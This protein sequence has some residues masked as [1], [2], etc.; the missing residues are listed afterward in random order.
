MKKRSV[1]NSQWIDNKLFDTIQNV[2]PIAC[3]DLLVLRACKKKFPELLLVKRKIYP[4]IGKWVLIGGRICYGETIMDTI[5]RQARHELNISVRVLRPWSEE[6]PLCVL[7]ASDADPQKHAIALAYPCE[8][9]KGTISASG[10]EFSEARWFSLRRLP[11]NIGFSK[12]HKREIDKLK[13]NIYLCQK[14]Y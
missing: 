5:N 3:V 10:P 13:S 9:I 14:K 2:I 12:L 8:A 6:H 1:L 11:R 7:S 4:E